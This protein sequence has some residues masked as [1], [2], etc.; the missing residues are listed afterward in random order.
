MSQKEPLIIGVDT[1]ILFDALGDNQ[2]RRTL[3]HLKHTNHEIVV[4]LTVAGELVMQGIQEGKIDQFYEII[5]LLKEIDATFLIPNP[6][7]RDC[8]SCIDDYLEENGRSSTT[9]RTH[10]AYSIAH[11][12]DYY[13]TTKSETRTLGVPKE[14]ETKLKITDIDKI[15]KILQKKK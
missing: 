9:D 8:C 3:N 5:E 1:C 7:L 6:I 12:C 11:N 4:P 2:I 14:C 15:K 10:L 13:L